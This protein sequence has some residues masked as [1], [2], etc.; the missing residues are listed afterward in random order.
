MNCL[1]CSFGRGEIPCLKVYEDEYTL[2]FMD[3]AQ[4][5]DGHMIAIPKAHVKSLLDCDAQTLAHWMNT[6][7]K[8]AKHCVEHCGYAGVNLLH[9][10]EECAGQSIPHLHLHIIPRKAE[11]GVDAWP[12]L[13][14]AVH[15]V[16]EMHQKLRM[17]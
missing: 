8:V 9:A 14:G 3:V 11:D 5:V 13:P 6:V 12:A 17:N 1:F 16:E 2:V 10:S 4:D 7:Q 15:M